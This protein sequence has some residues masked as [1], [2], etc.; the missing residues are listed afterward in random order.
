MM[1]NSN[2]NG[3]KRPKGFFALMQKIFGDKTVVSA[4]SKLSELLNDVGFITSVDRLDITPNSVDIGNAELLE[5]SDGRGV[6]RLRKSNGTTAVQAYANVGDSG[7]GEVDVFDAV[8]IMRGALYVS[9]NNRGCLL[10][11]DADGN[12]YA[13]TAEL[14]KKLQNL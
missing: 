6:I 8:G 5:S 3:P 14:I 10:L 4:P 12:A 2:K 11:K 7:G 1:T 9:K 13:L